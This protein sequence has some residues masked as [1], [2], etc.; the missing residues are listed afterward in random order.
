MVTRSGRQFGLMTKAPAWEP[1]S[2]TVAGEFDLGEELLLSSA[3]ESAVI[4][5]DTL[6]VLRI[7]YTL[8]GAEAVWG[9]VSGLSAADILVLA[10]AVV[11]SPVV[12]AAVLAAAGIAIDVAVIRWAFSHPLSAKH[13]KSPV[14]H[15]GFI[16]MGGPTQIKLWGK[17]SKD[18]LQFTRYW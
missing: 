16:K 13:V 5:T 15:S 8:G 10:A 3:G 11:T 12:I 7:M 6:G 1:M 14:P 4:A 9:I 2:P 18:A 17:P